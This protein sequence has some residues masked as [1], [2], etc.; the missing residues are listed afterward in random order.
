MQ[1]LSLATFIE[2]IFLKFNDFFGFSVLSTIKYT[3]YLTQYDC[4]FYSVIAIIKVNNLT[5]FKLIVVTISRSSIF[6]DFNKNF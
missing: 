3:V 1:F 5:Y 6:D 2:A 4:T